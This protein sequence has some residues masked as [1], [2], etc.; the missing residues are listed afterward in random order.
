MKLLYLSCHSILEF[1]EVSLFREM[2]IDVFSPGAYVEPANPGDPTMR[3]G[4]L[5]M[6][7]DPEILRQWHQLC[8][9][10]PGEDPKIAGLTKEFVDNFD[11]VMV[12]HVP[13]WIINNWENIKHKVVIWRTIGQ[14][15]NHQE[16]KLKPYREQG[17]KIVRYSPAEE[18]I[19]NYIGSDA[20]I[21]FYKDPEEYGNWTGEI[22]SIITV[23]QSLPKR[24]SHCNGPL[25][26]YV[27]SR[28][29]VDLYGP[30]NEDYANICTVQ[31]KTPYED[32]KKGFR[33][34]RAA[35]CLGT[36]P[37]SYTLNFIEAWMT[38]VPVFAPGPELGNPH[39]HIPG[40][41]LYEVSDLLE[42]GIT[43]FY[44]DN[45]SA[46]VNAMKW[47]LDNPVAAANVSRD[48]RSAAIATFGKP[49]IKQKWQEFLAQYE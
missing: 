15:I 29:P 17:L 2:G 8:Q 14:S 40:H 44:S 43:G 30:G 21:R 19:P 6:Q 1:D 7:Y 18:H 39:K 12:M 3:P 38:G 27:A 31:G 13:E 24:E 49:R 33:E 16:D 20:L 32:L 47:I 28:I 35:L 41:F 48:G 25:F 46:M 10:R 45:P 22:S 42:N 5:D 26:K 34:H 36:H 4:L 37:A 23:N 11:V 9:D